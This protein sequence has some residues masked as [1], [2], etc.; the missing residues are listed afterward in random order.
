VPLPD[1]L[2]RLLTAPGPSGYESVPAAVF[3]QAGRAFSQDVSIDV[4]GSAVVRVPGTTPGAPSLAI[5]GEIE[6]D[7]SACCTV[8]LVDCPRTCHHGPVGSA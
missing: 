8:R 2:E 5:V 3:A 4:V 1:V 6:D 7:A